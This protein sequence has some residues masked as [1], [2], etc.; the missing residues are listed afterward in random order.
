V[1]LSNGFKIIRNRDLPTSTHLTSTSG[2]LHV[3]S[4]EQ[5]H[6]GGITQQDA[7]QSFCKNSSASFKRSLNIKFVL[8]YMLHNI[9][10]CDLLHPIVACRTLQWFTDP[11]CTLDMRIYPNDMMMIIPL[12]LSYPKFNPDNHR[13][14]PRSQSPIVLSDSKKISSVFLSGCEVAKIGFFECGASTLYTIFQSDCPYE[15]CKNI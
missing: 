14:V 9:I 1:T 13:V 8:I 10:A 12:V 6:T 7:I 15:S 3:Y 2:A 4:Q 11:P 5:R